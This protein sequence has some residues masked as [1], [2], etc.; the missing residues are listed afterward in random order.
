MWELPASVALISCT[1]TRMRRGL[2]RSLVSLSAGALG[3]VLV[4][5]CGGKDEATES[6]VGEEGPTPEE[7]STSVGETLPD[8][9]TTTTPD[10]M[11]TTSGGSESSGGDVDTGSP[12]ILNP[13]GGG[14]TNECDIWAQDCPEGEKCM[15]W[16]NDGGGS[17]NA[18]RCSP[19]DE[20]P[21]QPGDTC[22][23]EGDG[24]S[25]IDDCDIASMCWD[26]DGKT[27]MG[28]CVGFC[29]GSEDAPFCSNPDEGCSI[30]NDGVLILCLAI[31]DPLLQ[32]C[33]EGSA[34][35]PEENGFFCSPDASGP[36]LGAIG[37]PCE[38]INVC[39]PG[40]WCAAAESV[41]DCMAA[42]G[43][44]AAF[45]DITDPASV[46]PD[47]TECVAWHTEGTAPPGEEDIGVC[48]LPQT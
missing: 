15:P 47:G 29:E 5:A 28:V 9:G 42:S 34:C 44:C 17:W 1:L 18:T 30:T 21:G 19:I 8:P 24:V 7:D 27:N 6:T 25:G 23:V 2:L 20:N 31:C 10:P 26:V 38:Y 12:F 39:D 45:C 35:Y 3:L 22:T 37:D 41:P 13:D 43:C 4:V 32:D 14:P 16:A 33:P 36:E 46:C 48:I 40:G 11:Q